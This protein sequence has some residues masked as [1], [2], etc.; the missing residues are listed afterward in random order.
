MTMYLQ[1]QNRQFGKYVGYGKGFHYLK[2]KLTYC[3]KQAIEY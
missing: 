3:L 1:N 2:L